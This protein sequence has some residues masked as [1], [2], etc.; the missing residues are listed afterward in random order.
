[1]A[2][3]I[4]ERK[5]RPCRLLPVSRLQTAKAGLWRAKNSTNAIKYLFCCVKRGYF[6]LFW[7]CFRYFDEDFQ[8]RAQFH[9]WRTLWKPQNDLQSAIFLK[10][11]AGNLTEQK[12]SAIPPFPYPAICPGCV[13]GHGF[14]F[15]RLPMGR[16]AENGLTL[17]CEGIHICHTSANHTGIK[18]QEMNL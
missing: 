5:K 6:G 1:M 12:Q 9:Q 8:K 15:D 2:V 10:Q 13:C 7:V 11:S 3:T 16:V 18:H 14:R 4:Q 17:G